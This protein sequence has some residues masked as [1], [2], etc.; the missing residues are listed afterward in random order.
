[1][2]RKKEYPIS[3]CCFSSFVKDSYFEFIDKDDNSYV[4]I[5]TCANCLKQASKATN[6]DREKFIGSLS[7]MIREEMDLYVHKS[8]IFETITITGEKYIEKLFWFFVRFYKVGEDEIK[9][10]KRNGFLVAI[11][12]IIWRIARDNTYLT[13]TMIGGLTNR[14]HSDVSIAL[15]KFDTNIEYWKHEHIRLRG[16]T[17]KEVYNHTL[18]FMKLWK[19]KTDKKK[20]GES[21]QKITAVY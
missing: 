2:K 13:I 8:Q 3:S 10:R 7:G 4:S 1:M 14:T 12:Y 21:C 9:S 5:G 11:R 15:S 18:K 17:F 6:E 19:I 16:R 20:I